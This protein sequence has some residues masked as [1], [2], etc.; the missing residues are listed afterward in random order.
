[1]FRFFHRYRVVL[2][3]AF[4]LLVSLG[5]AAV[6]R[7]AAYPIDP[8]GVVLLEVMHPLQVG[9]T[10]VSNYVGIA[11]DRY[12][13]L[14]SVREENEQL[15]KRVKELEQRDKYAKELVRANERLGKLLEFEQRLHGLGQTTIAASIVGRSPSAWVK[16]VVLDRGSTQGVSKGMAVLSPEGVVGQVV[17]TTPS[18]A[19]VLLV[20]D[21]NSAIDGLLSTSRTHGIVSGSRDGECTLKYVARLD[22]VIVGDT[23][24]TTGQD[25]IFPRDQVIGIVERVGAQ[26]GGMFQDVEVKLSV[27]LAKVEEVL[28]VA[29]GTVQ[30]AE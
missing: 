23:V 5:L 3:C 24:L 10:A 18:T 1:M 17:A 27:D 30:A 21:I 13:A 19:R 29:P 26:D 12:V 28:V 8:V 7:R 14:Q 16:T 15:R 2:S 6:N 22:E 20:A 4:F 25:G 9:V 11:W